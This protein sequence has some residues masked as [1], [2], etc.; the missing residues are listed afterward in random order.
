MAHASG[1]PIT[2]LKNSS[3]NV[4]VSKTPV[5]RTYEYETT[6][7]DILD[8]Y[9]DLDLD[10]DSDLNSIT[11]IEEIKSD[12]DGKPHLAT[13]DET[14]EKSE[15]QIIHPFTSDPTD[16]S[17]TLPP[18]AEPLSSPKAS[19][20]GR[21]VTKHQKRKNANVAVFKNISQGQLAA[22]HNASSA[23]AIP[24]TCYSS[25]IPHKAGLNIAPAKTSG[26]LRPNTFQTITSANVAFTAAKPPKSHY[27]LPSYLGQN[28][29]KKISGG[30]GANELVKLRGCDYTWRYHT[31]KS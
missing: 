14:G 12:E 20:L 13:P 16:I 26:K 6:I 25:Q 18:A 23:S 27:N 9:L 31:H 11:K 2:H 8:L 15:T 19:S 28:G 24:S 17:L 3:K 7:L 21:R 22:F 1:E 10:L 5:F 4:K 30:G 29:L